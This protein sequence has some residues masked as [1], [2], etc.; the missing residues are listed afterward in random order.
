MGQW[1]S[2]TKVLSLNMTLKEGQRKT[3]R[4]FSVF[5]VGSLVGLKLRVYG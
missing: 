2:A 4:H 3:E 1:G 5:V